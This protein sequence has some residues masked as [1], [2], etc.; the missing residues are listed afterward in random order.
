[1]DNKFGID[2]LTRP[3]A[4]RRPNLKRIQLRVDDDAG[5]PDSKRPHSSE[6]PLEIVNT[7]PDTPLQPVDSPL[8]IKSELSIAASDNLSVAS[9]PDNTIP[10][11]YTVQDRDVAM[12]LDRNEVYVYFDSAGRGITPTDIVRMKKSGININKEKEGW[13]SIY[14]R[15][16]L[17]AP[18]D[19]APVWAKNALTTNEPKASHLRE[20]LSQA[21][22]L[23]V[24]ANNYIQ[25]PALS[26]M[27]EP[28][29]AITRFIREAGLSND[30]IAPL[31]FPTDSNESVNF[32]Q[33]AHVDRPIRLMF[34]S[35]AYCISK[36]T[37]ELQTP[38]RDLYENLLSTARSKVRGVAGTLSVPKRVGT[39]VE[40]NNWSKENNK[41]MTNQAEMTRDMMKVYSVD[42]RV[43]GV[44]SLEPV[45]LLRRGP[46][47]ETEGGQKTESIQIH[48]RSAAGPGFG[49]AKQSEAW[50]TAVDMAQRFWR[51]RNLPLM[52]LC[53]AKQKNEV[54]QPDKFENTRIISVRCMAAEISG[55]AMCR[56]FY[57]TTGSKGWDEQAESKSL[58]GF[59]P[60]GDNFKELRKKVEKL[61]SVLV[62][63]AD[64]LYYMDNNTTISYDASKFEASHTKEK[65]ESAIKAMVATIDEAA[66]DNLGR[67]GPGKHLTS[68]SRDFILGAYTDSLVN[69]VSIR[70]TTQ[71]ITPGM[72]SGTSATFLINDLVMGAAVAKGVRMGIN[73]Q[74][75][76]QTI[77]FFKKCGIRMKV[78]VESRM[79]MDRVFSFGGLAE[80]QRLDLLGFDQLTTA[81]GG[82]R[83]QYLSLNEERAND[84]LVWSRN[85][86]NT[87]TIEDMNSARGKQLSMLISCQLN[88][89]GTYEPYRTPLN[90]A[91]MRL[92][93]EL[94]DEINAAASK[95]GVESSWI[96]ANGGVSVAVILGM[97]EGIEQGS[98][99]AWGL[100]RAAATDPI[101]QRG[102]PPAR[103]PKHPARTTS[104]VVTQTPTPST[105]RPTFKE[106]FQARSGLS[107]GRDATQEEIDKIKNSI[108]RHSGVAL[109]GPPGPE[110]I[111]KSIR[112]KKDIAEAAL[113][114]MALS[115][116]A[117]LG[118]VLQVL[119]PWAEGMAESGDLEYKPVTDQRLWGTW[120]G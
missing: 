55:G 97:R 53:Y 94:T 50:L 119:M 100:M 106:I 67:V 26:T 45:S 47:I 25:A 21:G 118:S 22:A 7:P 43:S 39:M 102:Q 110:I 63:Y 34:S 15:V 29:L 103:M 1:M 23:L 76:D 13:T 19:S 104:D 114:L 92:Q 89:L 6:S 3:V 99:L 8:S 72:P 112:S 32:H 35:L 98:E 66:I 48:P 30:E 51:G 116:K 93:E 37:P 9:S 81:A 79:T 109:R 17:T 82:E 113:K 60:L 105:N 5:G 77:D 59:N 52:R 54:Y 57:I 14:G 115:T 20:L 12:T 108:T 85:D 56:T 96:T 65:I 44:I 90:T 40:I 31:G 120:E 33:K 62:H 78:E 117:P 64:N 18:P 16:G 28:D 58:R 86:A 27:Q 68:K 38:M 46:Y 71:W 70:N 69:S 42:G 73:F 101:V 95:G 2:E 11:P 4:G 84:G 36:A 111:N 88:G 41:Y 75:P 91:V 49:Q 83:I 80:P 74:R 87:E 10:T 107:R 24:T 61:G